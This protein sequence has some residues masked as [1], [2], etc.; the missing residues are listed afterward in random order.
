MKR[1]SKCIFSTWSPAE[2]M[3]ARNRKVFCQS[4]L[5]RSFSPVGTK[6]SVNF[7][8]TSR[9]KFSGRIKSIFKNSEKRRT[10]RYQPA[11][12]KSTVKIRVGGEPNLKLRNRTRRVAR[13]VK[14]NLRAR[15]RYKHKHRPKKAKHRKIK[16]IRTKNRN[17]KKSLAKKSSIVAKLSIDDY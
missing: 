12:T 8:N 4:I 9:S 1:I 3:S 15:R 13:K 17:R 5:T 2:L 16:K 10:F 14:R 11:K 7:S 6:K